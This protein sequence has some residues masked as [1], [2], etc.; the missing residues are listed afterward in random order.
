[1]S[2]ERRGVFCY[3]RRPLLSFSDSEFELY[4]ILVFERAKIYTCSDDELCM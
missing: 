4:E 2:Y 3:L 1:M